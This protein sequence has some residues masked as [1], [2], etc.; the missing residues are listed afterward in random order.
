MAVTELSNNDHFLIVKQY[1]ELAEVPHM[2]FT[3][4]KI[5]TKVNNHQHRHVKTIV[6][7]LVEFLHF[8]TAMKMQN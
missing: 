8:C 2:R 3:A 7:T 5:T 6:N 1:S 4:T